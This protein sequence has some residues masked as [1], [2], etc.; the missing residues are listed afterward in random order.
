MNLI[1][2]LLL[3]A[4]LVYINYAADEPF[5]TTFPIGPDAGPQVLL[6]NRFT[7]RVEINRD[8]KEST[9]VIM[10]FDYDKRKAAINLQ[11]LNMETLLVFDYDTN[12]IHLVE[13]KPFFLIHIFNFQRFKFKLL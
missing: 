7:T 8:G 12:E 11:T 4:C 1:K 13:C 9:D 3:L 10:S 2:Q 5:C 6:P